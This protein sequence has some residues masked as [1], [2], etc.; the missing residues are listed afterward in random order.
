M[1][2]GQLTDHVTIPE[3]TGTTT[4]GDFDPPSYRMLRFLRLVLVLG[5]M[6]DA[7]SLE[8]SCGMEQESEPAEGAAGCGCDKLKRASGGPM[9]MTEPAGKY[10][11]AGSNGGASEAR[12]EENPVQSQV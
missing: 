6:R 4:R 9:M 5:F 10:S 3:V 2:P 8:G 11:S 1:L 12:G 7:F